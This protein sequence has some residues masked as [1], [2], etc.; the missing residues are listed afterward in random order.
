MGNIKGIVKIKEVEIYKDL[1]TDLYFEL[2]EEIDEF[3]KDPTIS[4][5]KIAV[6]KMKEFNEVKNK[7]VRKITDFWC[8]GE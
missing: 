5:K 3:I 2:T 4:N 8:K 1:M 6:E 7:I